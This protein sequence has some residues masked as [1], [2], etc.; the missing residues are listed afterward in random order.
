MQVTVSAQKMLHDIFQRNNKNIFRVFI[1][2]G[3]C[4]GFEYD[5]QLESEKNSDDYIVEL[6]H[7]SVVIDAL[8]WSY[9]S[10][11]TLDYHADL[12]GARFVIHN[13][14]VKKTCG[15]GASFSL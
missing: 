5:F 10:E 2:G 1:Q 4:S 7:G 13:P 9:L 8:S 12:N 14:L 3:G 15:C 11:A 6:P